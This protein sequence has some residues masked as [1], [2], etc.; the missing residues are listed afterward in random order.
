MESLCHSPSPEVTRLLFEGFRFRFIL[1]V[2]HSCIFVKGSARSPSLATQDLVWEGPFDNYAACS[3]SSEIAAFVHL[4]V[5]QWHLAVLPGLPP[6]NC[7]PLLGCWGFSNKGN[8]WLFCET[9]LLSLE[10]KFIL[11]GVWFLLLSTVS[12]FS[13]TTD[14][15]PRNKRCN[16][17]AVT[18]TH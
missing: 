14:M 16:F 7:R 1:T 12:T 13:L 10:G 11:S 4:H 9:F 3:G 6:L 17:K 15:P 5:W 2:V 18:Y 8:F